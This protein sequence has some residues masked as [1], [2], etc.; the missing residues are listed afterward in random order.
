MNTSL[1]III[2]FALDT[3]VSQRRVVFISDLKPAISEPRPLKVGVIWT[4][5]IYTIAI[6][7]NLQ[8][9]AVFISSMTLIL[10]DLSPVSLFRLVH[11]S[12]TATGSRFILTA[13]VMWTI[14]IFAVNQ[15]SAVFSSITSLNLHDRN[16]GPLSRLVHNTLTARWSH[17]SSNVIL[18]TV[19]VFARKSLVAHSLP[20]LPGLDP[21]CW[22]DPGPAWPDAGPVCPPHPAPLAG[23]SVVKRAFVVFAQYVEENCKN[24]CESC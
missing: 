21:A 17:C 24:E 19:I 12:L 5:S 15:W 3:T 14:L 13:S 4:I 9:R 11:N 16:P 7:V 23:N 2:V 18:T 22:P 20:Q 6:I 1:T 10:N 8:W